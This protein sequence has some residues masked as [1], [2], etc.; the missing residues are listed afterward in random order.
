[1]AVP[2]SETPAISVLICTRNR[3]DDVAR[4]LAS[5]RADGVPREGVEIVVIEETA[6]PAPIPGVRY[7]TVAPEGRGFAYV[8]NLA[9]QTARGRLLVFVDDDCE[10][11]RGWF[12]ALLAPLLADP[13]V[14]GVAGA[15]LVRDCNAVGYAESILGFPGGGLRYLDAAAGREVPT[16]HLSTCNCAYRREAIET[17][18]GFSPLAA[19]GGEDSL[20]AERVTARWPCRYVPAAIVYH[21]P[22]QRLPAVFRWFVRRG[23]AEM[24]ILPA[25]AQPAA[26]V[27]SLL[28]GSILLRALALA[29]VLAWLPWPVWITAPAL[30]SVYS[31]ALLRRFAFARRYPTHRRG[32]W[33]TP[34][35]KMVADAGAEIGRLRE[36]PGALRRRR[37]GGAT[38]E[39]P[40]GV[41]E[42]GGSGGHLG[43]PSQTARPAISVVLI[44]RDE[45]ARIRACLHSV[46]WA[47]EIVVVD[48]HSRDD[49]AAICRAY[50]ARVIERDMTAGFGEQKNF[51]VAQATHSWILSLDADEEVTPALRHAIEAAVTAPGGCVG[52]RMPRLTSYLGRFV[53]HCGWYPSPVLRLFRRDRGRFTDAL[54]HEEV[55]VDGPVGDLA[56][57]LLHR[58]YDSLADHVRKLLLYTAYDA[59]MRR[60][61][62]VRLGPLSAPWALVLKPTAVFLRKLVLQ[63]GF[64]EGWHGFVLSAMAALVVLVNAVRLAELTGWLG[65]PPAGDDDPSDPPTVLV[66]ANFAEVVGGGEESLLGL[67][68]ALDR[69]R[70]RVLGAVTAEGGVAARLRALDVPVSVVAL[71][72]VRPWT[73]PGM[74]LAWWRLRRLLVRER[75]AVVHAHG[76]R[77]ALYA[78][79][80]A[81]R[82][83]VPLVW[84]LR[85]DEPDPR[86]DPLLV[87]L[88]SAIVANS[89]ATA[90]RL[91]AGPVA[92]GKVTIVPNGVDLDR[93]APRAPDPAL[94]EALGLDPALPLV[95]FFGRL[96]HGKGVDVLL[97]AAA[98]VHTKL[99]SAF[100]VVGEGPLGERLAA[101][102]A[103]DGLPVR[104]AGRR[105]DVPEL[106]RLCAVVVLPS[107]REAFG[108]VLIE[109]MATGVPVV[110]TSVGGIPEVCV[111]G[112]TGLLVP[113]D[114]PEALAVAIALTLTD[115]A[116][117]AAR[118]AAAAA[119]VRARFDL[120]AHAAGVQAVYARMVGS[121]GAA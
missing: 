115:Q 72:P 102:A 39:L 17:A 10:V 108:R 46:R 37:V 26:V 33:L 9:V 16:G 107:R 109:A 93:F 40:G 106:M 13:G 113:P 86:L 95:G 98:R 87:R 53:R 94:R 99:P 42:R 41:P 62:G 47:D 61:R 51:A 25:A 83:G 67:T 66:L 28:R 69:R 23:R 14:G 90:A 78:G 68:A 30:L 89:A 31:A 111:D 5:L 12:D 8:R 57:D 56:E 75:V 60:R 38:A 63:Q 54:V 91:G 70:L 81:L 74:G 35:V 118:V 64:R 120:A 96:E 29:L 80:A 105:D 49:T 1:M 19:L 52:F 85:I 20:L 32:W 110:A 4:V 65:R 116:A 84:H 48:Q 27:R 6:E 11:E 101:R 18:G 43:A 76:S 104:F 112:V 45:A 22:R 82:L 100:L 103:G 44:T 73:L 21:K 117:T 92:A 58:S 119:D 59:R 50:G 114:D 7:V 34:L 79:L 24:L 3:R 2:A 55:V 36:L 71:P 15:V 77:G 121:G 88:A 97:E